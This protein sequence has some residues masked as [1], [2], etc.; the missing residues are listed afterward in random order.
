MAKVINLIDYQIHRM[1]KIISEQREK[2]LKRCQD[3]IR[4][5]DEV[6]EQIKKDKEG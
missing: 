3:H 5:L 6:L 4:H 2:S 1:Q